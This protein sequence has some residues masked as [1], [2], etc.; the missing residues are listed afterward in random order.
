MEL[1]PQIK[2]VNF[3]F[4]IGYNKKM[5]FFYSCAFQ[6]FYCEC[7]LKCKPVSEV[8]LS[9]EIHLVY[10]VPSYLDVNKRYLDSSVGFKSVIQ[11]SGYCI[12]LNGYD[13]IEK[14]IEDSFS[15]SSRQ[16][17]RSGKKRLE[18][19]FDISYKMY[20][21]DI[22][23][24]HFEELFD[25]FYAM[26]KLRAHEKGIDNG[27]LK[28]WDIYS[29][30]VYE[31]ILQRE[32][33]LFVIYD[34]GNAINISLNMHLKDIVF[35]FLTAYDIDYSKFRIGH[36]NWTVQLEWF[37][38]NKIRVVD[39]SKGN[40]A[41]KKRWANKKYTFSYHFFYEKSTIA[42]RMKVFWLI[43]KL[44]FK[45]LLRNQGLNLIYY[46][47]LRKLKNN[48]EFKKKSNYKLIDQTQLPDKISL[49][50]IAIDHE[51]PYMI[52][53]IIFNY[54]YLS[55]LNIKDI[56]IYKET[57]SENTFYISSKKEVVK[58]LVKDK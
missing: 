11:H 45:Q 28:R 58:L 29:S 53:R 7:L 10:D 3:M 46:S 56:V 52:K 25:K 6:N 41:Y 5:P 30:S 44:Q 17:L 49:L 54:L 47:V 35:L 9:N 19:C 12:D 43:K 27:N 31:M 51:D 21:G 40:V 26:L 16:L 36:T 55:S 2:R 23:H 33:S 14:Y 48:G 37:I 32:A 1:D 34:G 8:S 57:T 50:L 13:N 18:L 42:V 22:E 15:R 39:F 20:Y 4:E 24:K 38:K